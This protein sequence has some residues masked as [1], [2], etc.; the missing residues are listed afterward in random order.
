MEVRE[1]LRVA[2]CDASTANRDVGD[3][4]RLAAA[5]RTMFDAVF[6]IADI[7]ELADGTPW[8]EPPH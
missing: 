2:T 5:H 3:D 4:V 6:A 7:V 1:S 8:I